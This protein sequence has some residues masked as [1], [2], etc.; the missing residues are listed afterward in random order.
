MG[1]ACSLFVFYHAAGIK[2]N[3]F[4]YIKQFLGPIWWLIILM[5]PIEI[6][7]HFARPLS[8]T[9]RLFANMF[10]GEQVSNAFV[11]LTKVVIPVIFIGLHSFACILQAYIF[12]ILAMVYV[13]GAVSHEH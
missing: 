9:L 4:A 3:G 11:G 10:A 1:M 13:G 8:L 7:S 5:L 12:M 2:A 6:I